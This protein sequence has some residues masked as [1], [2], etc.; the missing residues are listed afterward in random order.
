MKPES[1][2]PIL[3]NSS[4]AA[5]AAEAAYHLGQNH[6][7]KEITTSAGAKILILPSG[8]RAAH[9]DHLEAA[10]RRFS[11]HLALFSAGDLARYVAE[12]TCTKKDRE[13]QPGS[14]KDRPLHHPVVF[15]DRSTT[16]I[17]AYLDYHHEHEARW[18]DHTAR[19]NY[20][21]SHQFTRWAK[22]NGKRMRQEEFALFLDEAKGDIQHPNAS[23][24]V[25]FAENMEHYSNVAFKSSV[26]TSSGEVSLVFS[27]EKNGDTSTPII[28]EF[29]LGLPF[30]Q[31][32]RDP[33]GQPIHVAVRARLFHR[34]VDTKDKDGNPTGAKHI[35]FWFELRNLEEIADKLFE[36]EVASLTKDLE[37]IATIYQGKAPAA[38]GPQS[39]D[40]DIGA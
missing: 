25:S 9:L 31:G 34:A 2:T 32:H 5:V 30:W 7:V 14:A 39:I 22:N 6:Q 8:H 16:S 38:P 29:T 36:E 33:D 10:P 23:Q 11:A 19:V 26:R 13:L 4:D 20:V 40:V 24:V 15:C 12:Q 35:V 27:D 3:A 21:P 18:L 28:E 17:I 1:D 37:G